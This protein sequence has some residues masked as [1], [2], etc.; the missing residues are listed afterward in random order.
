MSRAKTVASTNTI[1]KQEITYSMFV[2]KKTKK[3][4]QVA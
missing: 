3:K 4:D 1:Y 2:Q